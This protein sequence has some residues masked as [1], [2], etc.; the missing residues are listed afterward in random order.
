MDDLGEIAYQAYF[1]CLLNDHS[2]EA[3][4]WDDLPLIDRD[5]WN[6]AA[7]AIVEKLD[8]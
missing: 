1:D 8:G 5:G 6:A 2:C 7:Q 3:D 4:P